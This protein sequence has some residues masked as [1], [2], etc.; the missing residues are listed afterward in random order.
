[1]DDASALLESAFEAIALRGRGGILL[2]A[3]WPIFPLTAA[4]AEGGVG[5][6]A[7]PGFSSAAVAAARAFAWQHLRTHPELSFESRTDP[8][9]VAQTLPTALLETL[10][11]EDALPLVAVPSETAA[12][13]ALGVDPATIRDIAGGQDRPV[14]ASVSSKRLLNTLA[15][16]AAAGSAGVLQSQLP[17][18][19]GTTANNLF[20]QLKILEASGTAVRHPVVINAAAGFKGLVILLT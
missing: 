1:M 10:T 15:C 2:S 17:K 18:L 19:V 11:H 9:G 6:S 5:S 4:P 12:I 8:T 14:A 20:Y 3:L 7:A 13:W 16:I